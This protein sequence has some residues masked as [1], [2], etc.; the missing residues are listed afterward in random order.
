MGGTL[1]FPPCQVAARTAELMADTAELER[2]LA[3]GAQRAREVA[4][5]VLSEVYRKVG[6]L[7]PVG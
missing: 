3:A 1:R 7:P 6:F 4:A 5:P 2:V